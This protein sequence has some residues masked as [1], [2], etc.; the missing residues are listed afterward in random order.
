MRAFGPMWQSTQVLHE[1]ADGPCKASGSDL[2]E[3]KASKGGWL[4]P[5]QPGG[6]QRERVWLRTEPA[7]SSVH[8]G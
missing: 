1:P 2:R 4:P 6:L 5:R 7:V 8:L 3:Q